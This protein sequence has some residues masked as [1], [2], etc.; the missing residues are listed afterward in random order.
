MKLRWHDEL[1]GFRARA[2]PLLAADPVRH[3]VA[4]TALDGLLRGEPAETLVTVDE[5]GELVG[6]AL[7]AAGRRVVL[8]VPVRAAAPLA[9]LLATADAELPGAFGAVDVVEA[10][11]AAWT[12][13]TGGEIG[14]TVTQRLF[15]LGEL[16]E[17]VGV[18][19][20]ARHACDA[21]AELVARW[22]AAFAAEALHEQPETPAGKPEPVDP[23]VLVWELRG[24]PVALACARAPQAGMSR[25]GP[26]YTP[27]EQRGHG[28]APAVTAAATRFARQAGATDV[29]LFTDLSN[30]VSNRIYPRLGFRPVGDYREVALA[31]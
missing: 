2:W 17:P 11:A 25:I 29:V 3:T 26:V 12:A 9:E 16:V 23:G 18:A 8:A 10:F 7:R 22:R 4:L 27:P 24:V 21:D 28:Y 5:D 1:A 13:G 6:A 15:V 14:G 31:R 20:G 19:G 30:P